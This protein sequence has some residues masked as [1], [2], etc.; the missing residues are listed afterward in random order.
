MLQLGA[1]RTDTVVLSP[2]PDTDWFS[3]SCPAMPGV[4]SQG[5]GREQAMK[6]IREAM[7]LWL[8]VT[9]EEGGTPLEETPELIA[10]QVQF[11]LG[12]KAEEGW[13][14]IVETAQVSLAKVAA[15]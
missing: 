1:M 6:N 14:L 3:V 5:L 2:E 15:A 13:P 12:W 7:D 9:L 10:K 4:A 8:E 11:V